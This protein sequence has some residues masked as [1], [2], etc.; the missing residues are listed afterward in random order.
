M[1]GPIHCDKRAGLTRRNA[2]AAASLHLDRARWASLLRKLA[3]ECALPR[4]V[5]VL[6]RY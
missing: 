4:D 3:R 1:L 2:R 6:D 5:E